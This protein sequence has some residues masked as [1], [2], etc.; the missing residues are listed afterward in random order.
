MTNID[1]HFKERISAH[2]QSVEKLYQ[3]AV[4]KHDPKVI[5]EM[6]RLI[7]QN[8][9]LGTSRGQRIQGSRA[10]GQFF[11]GMRRQGKVDL[12]FSLKRF[13]ILPTAHPVRTSNP[14][15]KKV[16]V[17]HACYYIMEFRL[18]GSVLTGGLVGTALHIGGCPIK[19]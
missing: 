17:E 5:G 7:G 1:S 4:R 2:Y 10:I 16:P 6:G 18:K 9:I 13:W 14:R 19:P 15:G 8:V 11:E 12:K 3:K